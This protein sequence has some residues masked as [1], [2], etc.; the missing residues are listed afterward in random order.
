MLDD[1]EKEEQLYFN[2]LGQENSWD[3][4]AVAYV[5]LLRELRAVDNE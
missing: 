5:E 3:M 4:H 2:T 1:W